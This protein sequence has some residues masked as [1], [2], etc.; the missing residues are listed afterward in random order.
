MTTLIPK[1]MPL[2][3]SIVVPIYNEEES[4]EKLLAGILEVTKQFDFAYEIIFVDDGSQD[5]TWAIIEQLKKTTP[6]L[7]KTNRIS[8]I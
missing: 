4:V 1:D 5:N 3:L 8:C 2:Y 6:Q 7:K